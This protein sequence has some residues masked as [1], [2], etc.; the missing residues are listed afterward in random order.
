MHA[1][2]LL[3]FLVHIYILLRR[4]VTVAPCVPLTMHDC[5]MLGY[6]NIP[7]PSSLRSPVSLDIVNF[8]HSTAKFTRECTFHGGVYG[9][10]L[11]FCFII[12]S[13]YFKVVYKRTCTILRTIFFLF[14]FLFFFFFLFLF[15]CA[16]GRARYPVPFIPWTAT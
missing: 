6:S 2:S 12:P 8:V 3:A 1:Y 14:F 7:S 9:R 13:C 15:S 5:R 16:F 10:P 4:C 11:G